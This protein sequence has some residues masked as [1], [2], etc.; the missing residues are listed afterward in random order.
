MNAHQPMK[1]AGRAGLDLGGRSHRVPGG[2][3]RRIA[4]RVPRDASEAN[5]L[6]PNAAAREA[7]PARGTLAAEPV[8]GRTL[9]DLR[10]EL[11]P[12]IIAAV[13]AAVAVLLVGA[14]PAL[15]QQG[16]GGDSINSAITSLNQWLATIVVSLGGTAL[17]IC[18][19]VWLFS[20]SDSKRREGA[21]RWM[22]SIVVAIFVGLSVPAIIAVIQGFAGGGGG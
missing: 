13:V 1:A 2:L 12:A 17:L 19:I 7:L 6:M 4:R 10:A 11:P 15:A 16:G 5:T 21:V 3:A 8:L 20:G 18:V 22:G 9:A 14:D